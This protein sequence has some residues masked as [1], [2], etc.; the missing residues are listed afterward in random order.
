MAVQVSTIQRDGVHCH[1]MYK[2]RCLTEVC[3]VAL[4]CACVS[5][6]GSVVIILVQ[7]SGWF[8]H[9]PEK[10]RMAVSGHVFVSAV[11]GYF[12]ESVSTVC[13]RHTNMH[14]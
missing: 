1:H 13:A 6:L 12:P 5:L 8:Q 11:N 3:F 14:I 7:L 10:Q 4:D 9:Q 2:V